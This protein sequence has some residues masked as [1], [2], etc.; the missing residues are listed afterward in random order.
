[1]SKSVFCIARTRPQAEEIINEL[2]ETGL[3]LTDISVLYP[4]S[5]AQRE[6]VHEHA[7]KAPEGAATGAATGGLAGGVIGLLAGVGA[8]TIPGIGLFFA[9]GPIMAALSGA[10]VGVAT[11]GLVG[12]LIGLGIPE[13]EAQHYEDKL[14]RGN[15]FISVH[16]ADAETADLVRA[17]FA[18]EEAEDIGTTTEEAVGAGR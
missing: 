14:H 5:T 8:L 3:P 12:G 2:Q 18:A 4:D 17:V 7:T 9:A 13:S 1:M 15:Y 11:G 6:I 16:V 10:A